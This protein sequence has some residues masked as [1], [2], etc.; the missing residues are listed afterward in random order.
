MSKA[1]FVCMWL[2]AACAT[3]G[4]G[5]GGDGPADAAVSRQDSSSIVQVDAAVRDAAVQQDAQVSQ[6]TPDAATGS[7][8]LF[9]ADNTTC[10]V[11]GECC[12]N[13]GGPGFCSPVS[14][15]GNSTCIPD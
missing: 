2:L 1:T 7:G 8:G 10:T 6:V 15:I 9:C 12:V 4:S 14:P 13:L 3:G 11:A 5:G